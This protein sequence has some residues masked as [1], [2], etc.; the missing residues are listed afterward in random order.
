M[1]SQFVPSTGAWLAASTA[2][3][4]ASQLLEEGFL[5]DLDSPSPTANLRAI[6]CIRNFVTA[7]P[8][9]KQIVVNHE[10]IRR[11]IISLG[12]SVATSVDYS[13]SFKRNLLCLYSSF[14]CGV[15]SFAEELCGQKRF[16]HD[17]LSAANFE[18]EGTDV[19][20]REAIMLFLKT[21]FEA[22]NLDRDLES[23]PVFKKQTALDL[24]TADQFGS[25]ISLSDQLFSRLR[26]APNQE[27]LAA[28]T[29]T[30]IC[31]TKL[32]A[33]LVTHPELASRG[34]PDL[35][36]MAHQR[37]MATACPRHA[38]ILHQER[39]LILPF[40]LARRAPCPNAAI[41]TVSGA[42]PR[43]P[44]S[45]PQ[46]ASEIARFSLKTLF[47]TLYH[48]PPAFEMFKSVLSETDPPAL[49]SIYSH[50]SQPYSRC[51]LGS[52]RGRLLNPDCR[53]R[54]TCSDPII[55]R[56]TYQFPRS[57]S[58]SSVENDDSS[59]QDEE[60]LD[61]YSP[62]GA[63][64]LSGTADRMTCLLVGL[65]RGVLFWRCSSH[66]EAS[67][68]V[69]DR[70]GNET[71]CSD[72]LGL[73]DDQISLKILQ[74][75]TQYSLPLSG[76]S[77][78]T[79]ACHVIILLLK[80]RKSLHRHLLY[81]QILAPEF[82]DSVSCL[83]KALQSA[84]D[85]NDHSDFLEQLTPFSRLF[86][87]LAS[88]YED[89]RVRIGELSMTKAL[90][91]MFVTHPS[92]NASSTIPCLN[93]TLT[94]CQLLHALSRSVALQHTLFADTSIINC[95][96]KI[97]TRLLPMLPSDP[98]YAQIVL[99]AS[100]AL[101][102][103]QLCQLDGF[104]ES[105]NNSLD[106][107]H[108]LLVVG[109]PSGN[110][111]L[112]L[113]LN[114]LWGLSNA[115][116]SVAID[117]DTRQETVERL[118]VGR[119]IPEVI[120]QCCALIS[121]DSEESMDA[122]SSDTSNEGSQAEVKVFSE[123][124]GTVL[125]SGPS[126]AQLKSHF[127]H[128]GIILLRNLFSLKAVPVADYSKNVF[129][130]L[131]R[132]LSTSPS[133]ST[134]YEV[135]ESCGDCQCLEWFSKKK[136]EVS[137]FAYFTYSK[138]CTLQRNQIHLSPGEVYSQLCVDPQICA[139]ACHALGPKHVT[140]SEK[141]LAS[142]L[143]CTAD[144]SHALAVLANTLTN[145][146]ALSQFWHHS[147][148]TKAL[149]A[150]ITADADIS[151]K[152]GA[153]LVAVNLLETPERKSSHQHTFAFAVVCIIRSKTVDLIL[154]G[155][156]L[157][158]SVGGDSFGELFTRILSLL[159]FDDSRGCR[160]TYSVPSSS[161]RRRSSPRS[162]QR[163][164]SAAVTRQSPERVCS[165]SEI[166]ETSLG[167]FGSPEVEEETQEVQLLRLLGSFI[168]LFFYPEASTPDSRQSLREVWDWQCQCGRS[169]DPG[170]GQPRRW[171]GKRL[172]C[173]SP[174]F[175]LSHHRSS[176]SFQQ[177]R[178]AKLSLAKDFTEASGAMGGLK[179]LLACL[180]KDNE[181]DDGL[182][183]SPQGRTETS[184]GAVSEAEF[185]DD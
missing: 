145:G 53:P 133:A 173:T 168:N 110:A 36:R 10:A 98:A 66:T 17:L 78:N 169:G 117:G 166:W 18:C 129:S 163:P 14:L 135:V 140:V 171:R 75:L 136:V 118:A 76:T 30:L 134:K 159:L 49:I 67:I 184:G 167:A 54:E 106:L 97:C 148:L 124:S 56:S 47:F 177:H 172:N 80:Q 174:P 42:A 52:A 20:L 22:D 153:V 1:T 68:V 41:H 93:L 38:P 40:D 43:W 119:I 86:A 149:S 84:Y 24:F 178:Q 55:Y 8:M 29:N 85:Y 7:N 114:G 151:V 63:F 57:P 100:S 157:A 185:E 96:I 104:E 99:A 26:G 39:S 35:L 73:S 116:A 103:L 183:S 144:G 108:Q 83:L 120:S 181:G 154:S 15:P 162:P 11:R 170:E 158:T 101:V 107:F 141:A 58:S 113:R 21:F 70:F 125:N 45:S 23:V 164:S 33:L 112:S 139:A 61:L 105:R 64:G 137:W 160:S 156:A 128:K 138:K 127:I 142:I 176:G 79:W 109:N 51:F 130:F 132:V 4:G 92:L 62:D 111:V 155:S 161:W 48:V 91:Q 37:V 87:C 31:L 69:C 123:T 9:N 165:P 94:L 182:S 5:R 25:L 122:E 72:G 90:I 74:P 82:D 71:L 180:L 131:A 121:S 12:T 150:T 65:L 77:V 59:K 146:D 102:N 81:S 179:D 126:W 115:A 89:V 147:E 95:L 3:T 44:L 34:G 46:C 143:A 13:A 2:W 88:T 16:L 27:N 175:F 152:C 32:L 6:R 50:L 60:E 19:A 28:I